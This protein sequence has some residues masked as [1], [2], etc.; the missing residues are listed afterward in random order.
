MDRTPDISSI[1][2]EEL[3]NYGAEVSGGFVYIIRVDKKRFIDIHDLPDRWIF[4]LREEPST[5][6]EEVAI[7]RG[8]EITCMNE[9]KDLYFCLTAKK[10]RRKRQ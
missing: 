1:T 7:F 8:R 6:Y 4:H 2:A 9:I 10:L 5:K 3:V